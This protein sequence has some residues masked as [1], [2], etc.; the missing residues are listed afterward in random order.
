MTHTEFVQA[1]RNAADFFEARPELGNPCFDWLDFCYS[2]KVNNITIDSREGLAEFARIVGGHIDKIEDDEF[3]R[4]I[5]KRNGFTVKALAYRAA[6]CEKI[7]I[8]SKIEPEHIIPARPEQLIPEQVVP[9]YG[10]RCPSLLAPASESV[11]A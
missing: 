3:Y 5:A 4:L 7:Q 10:W 11:S 1:L 9:V 8:G 6:V 2:G